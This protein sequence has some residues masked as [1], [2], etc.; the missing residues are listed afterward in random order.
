MI[1]DACG[2]VYNPYH[3]W[4]VMFPPVP[5]P[6]IDEQKV[7]QV[8]TTRFFARKNFCVFFCVQ[9]GAPTFKVLH[10][11]DTHYDPYYL[12]GSNAD[13][14]EPLCCRLTNGVAA[15]KEQAAGKYVFWFLVSYVT[16]VLA[17]K[18]NL[19]LL[20]SLFSHRW[21][22]YRKCDTPKITVDNMLKH[23]SETHP[24]SR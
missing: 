4:E 10:L 20:I 21:G 16:C 1:G 14:A 6:N 12:E 11:S 3:E 18:S 15:S 2:D 7:P 13:C 9:A 17:R 8:I 23:I 22:D 19:H 24:V 5:K